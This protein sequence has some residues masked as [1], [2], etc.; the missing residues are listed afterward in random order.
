LQQLLRNKYLG[1]KTI[2]QVCKRLG[3]SQFWKG[4]MNIRDEF[5]C[6]CN[7]ILKIGRKLDFERIDGSR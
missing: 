2:T 5:L 3:N 7:F 6:F 1:E 4:L